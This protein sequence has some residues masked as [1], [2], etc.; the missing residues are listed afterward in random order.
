MN[1]VNA[2][3]QSGFISNDTKKQLTDLISSGMNTG[4]YTEL[5]GLITQQCRLASPDNHF[6]D[7]MREFLDK[8][9]QQ[10]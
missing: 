6:W 8:E 7:Q 5:G 1:D 3:Y 10:E 2:M 9:V 4:D